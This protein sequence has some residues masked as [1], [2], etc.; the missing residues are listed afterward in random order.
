MVLW[1]SEFMKRKANIL[2][3]FSNRSETASLYYSD[4][5]PPANPTGFVSNHQ[6]YNSISLIW[7][8]NTEIDFSSYNIYKSFDG[9][10]WSSAPLATVTSTSYVDHLLSDET[11]YYYRLQ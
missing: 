8:K 6:E 9:V 3:T 5:T 10:I 4:D 2:G 7:D 1:M 11:T